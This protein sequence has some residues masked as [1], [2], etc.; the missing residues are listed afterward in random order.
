MFVAS[1]SLWRL[2]SRVTSDNCVR[3]KDSKQTLD[4]SPGR[5]LFPELQ[6]FEG[7]GPWAVSSELRWTEG[8]SLCGWDVSTHTSS[9]ADFPGVRRKCWK[10]ERKW[11]IWWVD[12]AKVTHYMLFQ[13]VIRLL[14]LF[15]LERYWD[16]QAGK[17]LCF[18]IIFSAQNS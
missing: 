18:E 12:D 9:R 14:Y 13:E 2:R 7:V 5:A 6:G 10:M 17:S 4:K 3:C 16:T 15:S 11:G 8:Y 1:D